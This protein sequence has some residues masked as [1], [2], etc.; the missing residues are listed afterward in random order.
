MT[1]QY[2]KQL[3]I[4][5]IIYYVFSALGALSSV[6]CSLGLF[7]GLQSFLGFTTGIM[8]A[9]AAGLVMLGLTY[10]FY[11]ALA[12]NLS[13]QKGH[14]Y[15]AITSGINC[16]TFPIGTALGIWTLILINKPEIKALFNPNA[17]ILTMNIDPSA[18]E[19]NND[20]TA[21]VT[22]E[23]W[24]SDAVKTE[25][26]ESNDD[27]VDEIIYEPKLAET[28]IEPVITTEY[29]PEPKANTKNNAAKNGQYSA[30]FANENN[31]WLKHTQQ[32]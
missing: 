9:G 2:L 30:L 22:V 4:I 10:V 21:I 32:P 26:Q 27:V 11:F 23:T 17:Q 19:E 14:L 6:I 20:E 13:K 3:K 7:F 1:E 24:G 31:P 28:V 16:L 25:I 5:S 12:Q 29:Q 18:A 15:C 8:I